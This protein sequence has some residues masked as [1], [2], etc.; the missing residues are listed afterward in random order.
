MIK[1][2][3]DQFYYYQGTETLAPCSPAHQVVMARF[4][5]I[6][7]DQLTDFIKISRIGQ[8]GNNRAVVESQ[9]SIF[10]GDNHF[11]KERTKK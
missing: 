10:I 1:A 7:V 6:G 8:R 9:E 4:L 3:G 2:S 11:G 5:P